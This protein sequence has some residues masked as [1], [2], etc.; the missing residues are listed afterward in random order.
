MTPK[1]PKKPRGKAPSKLEHP[2]MERLMFGSGRVRRFTQDTP[3]LPDVWLAY[4]NCL[5]DEA[6][7][8]GEDG[9]PFPPLKL[10]LTPYRDT[11]VGD[12]RNR[13]RE[14]LRSERVRSSMA[15]QSIRPAS[16]ASLMT[17]PSA[18]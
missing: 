8:A 1:T 10:L 5:G 2:L 3:V 13:L 11:Q 4:A 18:L 6:R 17:A 16:R 9:D 7:A 15:S 14:R 12:L